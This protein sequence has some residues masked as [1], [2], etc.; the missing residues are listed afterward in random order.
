MSRVVNTDNPGKNRNRMMRTAA[1]LLR[2][3]SQKT[4][5]DSEAKDMVAQLVFCLRDVEDGI[6]AS[7]VVWEKRD[8]WIKAEQLRQRWAWAGNSAARLESV[9]R[10][11]AWEILPGIMVDLLGHFA[12]IK[13]TKL[14]RDASA[15]QG[16]FQ[17]LREEWES[18]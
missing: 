16:A 11:E 4:E 8:Y 13:I 1:E 5:L 12:E 18:S 7:A 14:T 17:R 10:G 9:I 3:L 6:E 15:W 2:H